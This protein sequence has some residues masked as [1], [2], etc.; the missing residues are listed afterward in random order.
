MCQAIEL[1]S[2]AA[3]MTGTFG[4]ST[5]WVMNGELPTLEEEESAKSVEIGREL[6]T[7]RQE[8]G[9]GAKRIRSG[10]MTSVGRVPNSGA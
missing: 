10:Y 3:R 1:G 5:S 9:S 4:S 8:T 7:L 6:P 2:C